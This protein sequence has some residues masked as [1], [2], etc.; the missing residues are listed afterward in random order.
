MSDL[1]DRDPADVSK[2]DFVKMNKLR[3]DLSKL[4]REKFDKMNRDENG[5]R[6]IL[7]LSLCRVYLI[8]GDITMPRNSIAEETSLCRYINTVSLDHLNLKT[9]ERPRL[10]AADMIG[11]ER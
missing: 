1:L 7:I 11:V 5:A 4:S 8:L 10:T 2:E 3:R 6:S 9:E